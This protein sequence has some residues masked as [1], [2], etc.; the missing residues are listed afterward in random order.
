MEGWLCGAGDVI[1]E[2]IGDI[3]EGGGVGI[4]EVSKVEVVDKDGDKLG[5]GVWGEREVAYVSK[6]EVAWGEEGEE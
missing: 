4:R 2:C 3:V 1:V 6:L 5:D